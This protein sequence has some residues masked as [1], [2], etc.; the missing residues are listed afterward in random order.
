MAPSDIVRVLSGGD[1]R[2]LHKVD[3]VVR[4]VLRNPRSFAALVAAMFADDDVVRMRAGDAVEK[5]GRTVL[6]CSRDT[7]VKFCACC[8]RR[9][10]HFWHAAQMIPRLRLAPKQRSRIVSVLWD[11]TKDSS[12]IVKT[13][14]M[15]ALN[16]LAGS[17]RTLKPRVRCQLAVWIASATP[18]LRARARRLQRSLEANFGD[19]NAP[20][21]RPR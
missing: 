14:A 20:R 4:Q 1:R 7:A 12:N 5:V 21:K 19:R 8:T 13:T 3:S 18:S 16:D 15:E 9:S 10:R 11:W 17:D 2:S 6:S